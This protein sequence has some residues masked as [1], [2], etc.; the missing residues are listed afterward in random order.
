MENRDKTPK[1][2]ANMKPLGLE[3]RGKPLAIVAPWGLFKFDTVHLCAITGCTLRA[4]YCSF[5]VF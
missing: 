2:Q 3:M 4:V 1:A 5:T